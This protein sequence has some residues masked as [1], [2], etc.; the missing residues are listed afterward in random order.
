[1]LKQIINIAQGADILAQ[2][3]E[4]WFTMKGAEILLQYL[5]DLSEDTWQDIE[6]DE[7]AIRC[8]YSE[9]TFEE[10]SKDYNYGYLLEDIDFDINDLDDDD[11][12]KILNFLKTETTVLEVDEDTVIIQNF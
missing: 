11:K 1:M 7:I 8:D 10:L 12:E 5:E 6:F 3:K 2:N 4:N 9:Y